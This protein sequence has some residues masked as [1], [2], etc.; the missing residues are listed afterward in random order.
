MITEAREHRD[1]KT[2]ENKRAQNEGMSTQEGME[3]RA[4][5]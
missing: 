5:R 4:H 2:Q 1:T 3:M